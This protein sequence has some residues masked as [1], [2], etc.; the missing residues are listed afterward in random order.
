M[1]RTPPP[2]LTLRPTGTED[3]RDRAEQLLDDLVIAMARRDALAALAE[4]E[5]ARE[6]RRDLRQV[7]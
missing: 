4:E 5:L 1:S 2:Q 3:A 6:T 7:F